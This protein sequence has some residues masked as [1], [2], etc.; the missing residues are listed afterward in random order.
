MKILRSIAVLSLAA[1][2]AACGDDG[3]SLDSVGLEGTWDA[4]VI[5]FTSNSD[6]LA[7]VDIAQRDGATFRLIVD[8]TGTASSLFDNGIGGSSSD[9]GTLNSEASRGRK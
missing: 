1:I 8:A 6:P 9:S 5:E 3:T 2:T 4:T 7:V